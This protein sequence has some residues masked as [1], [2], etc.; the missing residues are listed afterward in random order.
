MLVRL[1]AAAHADSS[2][3]GDRRGGACVSVSGLPVGA[4]GSFRQ[5]ARTGAGVRLID[6]ILLVSAGILTVLVIML[7]A[8]SFRDFSIFTAE[9]HARSVAET[10]KVGLTESMINGTINKR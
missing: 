1:A 7:T 9:R 4:A 6:K 3:V 10:I 2:E 5:R 8:L